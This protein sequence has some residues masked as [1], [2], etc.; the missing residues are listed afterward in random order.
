MSARKHRL[1]RLER[2]ACDLRNL[3]PGSSDQLS[4]DGNYAITPAYTDNA[5]QVVGEQLSK[6][7]VRLASILN[8]GLK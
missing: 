2:S 4:R 3:K 7:G 5:T 8:E 6:A 1:R